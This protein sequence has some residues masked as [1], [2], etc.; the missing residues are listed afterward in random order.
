MRYPGI[1]ANMYMLLNN[2]SIVYLGWF[3]PFD[4]QGQNNIELVNCWMLH[5]IA[6]SLLLLV[7][8]MP[9]PETEINLGWFVIAMVGLLF[10]INFGYMMSITLRGLFRKL[11]LMK[12]KRDHERWLKS[13]A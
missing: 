1:L 6:Y 5:M 7:N 12:L 2:F 11:Y 3:R 10:L 13:K 4:S 8:L 9:N